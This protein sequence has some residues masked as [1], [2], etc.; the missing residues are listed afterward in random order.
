MVWSWV[1]SCFLPKCPAHCQRAGWIMSYAPPCVISCYFLAIK[2]P[3]LWVA[4]SLQADVDLVKTNLEDR[5]SLLDNSF[6][7]VPLRVHSWQISWVFIWF[8]IPL[9]DLSS[10][11]YLV[12]C[13]HLMCWCTMVQLSKV[14]LKDHLVRVVTGTCPHSRDRESVIVEYHSMHTFQLSCHTHPVV[15]LCHIQ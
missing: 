15:R 13:D 14:Y 8:I 11:K 2:T 9:S 10:D 6:T 12:Q 3:V 5:D 1:Q 7:N 4:G